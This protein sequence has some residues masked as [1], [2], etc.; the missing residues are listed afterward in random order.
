MGWV[1][2]Y[3]PVGG[4]WVSALLAAAPIVVLLAA[5]GVFRR[6]AHLSAALAL[7]TALGI[8][9]FSYGMPVGLAGNAALLGLIFGI[10][11]IAWIAFHAVFF[12]NV[13]VA[14]GR[15]ESIK[16]ALAGFSPDRRIQALLIAFGF[17]ALLEGV[18]GGGSPIAITA[19][20]MA[21]LGFPPIKAVVLALLANTAP[22]AFGG[23]GNPMIV[24]GSVTA[25]LLGV[26]TEEATQL[27]SAMSGRQLPFLALIIPAF[28]VVVLAGWRRMVEV[29][30]AL[31]VTGGSFAIT[32]FLISNYVSPSLVDVGA[33]LAAMGSLWVLTRFWRPR[34]VW[35][36]AAEDAE[37]EGADAA[38][39]AESTGPG[40]RRTRA[41]ATSVPGA[42]GAEADGGSKASA[43]A[44]STRSGS[45]GG[46]LYAWMPYLILI[47]VIVLSRIGTLFPG[48][49]G[50]LDVT[51][52]LQRATVDIPWPGLHEA[53]VRV[54]P[55]TPENA[56]YPAVLTLDLL[57]SPGSVALF[58]T[59]LAGLLMGARP[60]SL[61]RVYGQTI[62]QMRWALATIMMIL[63]ISFVMN[64]S[65][66]T[67]TLGLAFATTGVLFPLFSAFIG[68]LGVF[69]TGS[70]AS[71][72]SL[73][74]PMQVI[75]AQ[76]LG[77]DPTLAGGTNSSGGVMGKMI[78]PQN[79]AVGATA[80]GQSGKESLLLRKTFLWSVLLT[81]AVGVIALLQATVFTGMIPQ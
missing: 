81:L 7:L 30:P 40:P 33:A 14:T 23:L 12:H 54:P 36:F 5:L 56:D 11:P 18:A 20:M 28:M 6:S 25:P 51:A 76:Q 49:P 34:E 55:I 60:V 26:E 53:V 73:F 29:W 41:D 15:F 59:I 46:G 38:R 72:N 57:F 63:S 8:A 69:L 74:G 10:W 32:Q 79:L 45:V 2:D 78:S 64:Y 21:A 35:R 61:L 24:L 71:A 58:A 44:A 31:L 9:V 77:I 65:G 47:A 19:A 13:T 3:E 42:T 70:D 22:V 52:L 4:L 50:W 37:A 17:G 75:S 68:W 67:S 16:A 66:A 62:V 80:I 27:F 39:Q 48:L 1:Q 43:A